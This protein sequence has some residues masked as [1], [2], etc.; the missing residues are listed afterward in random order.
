MVG[1]GLTRLTSQKNN[2]RKMCASTTHVDIYVR[3]IVCAKYDV[4]FEN[5]PRM[6]WYGL[7]AQTTK[8]EKFQE[9]SRNVVD[10][11]VRGCGLSNF[12]F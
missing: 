3:P 5:V 2:G 4:F 6:L 9:M 1:G 11:G 8:N 7:M 12:V 10:F